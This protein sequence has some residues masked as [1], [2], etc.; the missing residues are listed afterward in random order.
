M[1]KQNQ[2]QKIHICSRRITREIMVQK[3]G[4]EGNKTWYKIGQKTW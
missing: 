4:K 2:K 1:Q 3:E